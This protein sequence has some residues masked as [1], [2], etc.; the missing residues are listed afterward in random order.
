MTVIKID[1]HTVSVG[2]AI[3]A[4]PGDELLIVNAVCIG[5]HTPIGRSNGAA[6]AKAEP[7]RLP[8]P[9]AK[10]KPQGRPRGIHATRSSLRKLEAADK[11]L[12]AVL[13]G[14]SLNTTMIFERLAIPKKDTPQREFFRRRVDR[15]AASGRIRPTQTSDG[16]RRVT[17]ELVPE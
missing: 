3:H 2:A 10:R 7:L 13:A 6:P 17:W 11:R 8:A 4:R 16:E 15:L 5:V 9:Q 1:A 14:G 12:L